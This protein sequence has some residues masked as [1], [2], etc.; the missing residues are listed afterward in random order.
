MINLQSRKIS[1]L[2]SIIVLNNY[3]KTKRKDLLMNKT[4]VFLTFLFVLMTLPTACA[5]FFF[6]DL[7]SSESGL[8][9]IMLC[10]CVSFSYHGLHFFINLISNRVFR[11]EFLKICRLDSNQFLI[12]FNILYFEHQSMLFL[13]TICGF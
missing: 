6:N 13:V 9:M 5:S 2:K 3:K 10:N 12:D 4:I 8:I 1:N 11:R 7:Y